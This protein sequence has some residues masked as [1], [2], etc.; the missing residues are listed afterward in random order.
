MGTLLRRLDNSVIRSDINP[1]V[2]LSEVFQLCDELSDLGEAVSDERLTTIILDALPEE[3]YFTNKMKSIRDP[4]LGLGQIISMM[5]TIFI[6]IRRGRQFPKG[7]KC[8][9]VKFVIIAVVSQ[10]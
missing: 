8:G 10:Q 7:V 6:T 9:I 2:F 5:K 3:I 4:E 1:D